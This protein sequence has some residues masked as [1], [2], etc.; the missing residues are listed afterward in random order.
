MKSISKPGKKASLIFYIFPSHFP[1][2]LS[3]PP[4]LMAQKHRNSKAGVWHTEASSAWWSLPLPE[5]HLDPEAGRSVGLCEQHF[6]E[7]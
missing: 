6:R 7:A 2:T 5:V 3:T 1:P 4:Q